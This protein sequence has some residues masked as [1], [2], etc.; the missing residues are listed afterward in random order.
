MVD[1]GAYKGE[2]L[3]MKNMKLIDSPCKPQVRKAAM[4]EKTVVLLIIPIPKISCMIKI[5]RNKR[6]R[7]LKTKI[8][9]GSQ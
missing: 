2:C 5:K 9:D 4:Q 7:N 8:L 6:N 1:L 3:D